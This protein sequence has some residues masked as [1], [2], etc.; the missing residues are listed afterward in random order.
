[1]AQG[2][3]AGCYALPFVSNPLMPVCP[4]IPHNAHPTARTAPTCQ[5]CHYVNANAA[6]T[7]MDSLVR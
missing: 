7:E 5:V 1:M 4:P 2:T 3:D 6:V